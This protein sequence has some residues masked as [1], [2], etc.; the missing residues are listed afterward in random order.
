MSNEIRRNDNFLAKARKLSILLISLDVFVIRQHYVRILYISGIIEVSQVSE[1]KYNSELYKC[2]HFSHGPFK[3]VFPVF[4]LSCL[5]KTVF[6]V[7]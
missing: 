3:I 7:R 5:I 4:L 6:Y 1:A 2:C